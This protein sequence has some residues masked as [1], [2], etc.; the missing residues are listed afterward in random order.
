[1]LLA[2]I[3]GFDFTAIGKRGIAKKEKKAKGKEQERLATLLVR[4]TVR[5]ETARAE[6]PTAVVTVPAESGK[7]HESPLPRI[8]QEQSAT[9]APVVPAPDQAMTQQANEKLRLAQQ[10]ELQ[11]LAQRGT[12][13]QEGMVLIPAGEFL[14]GAEDGLRDARPMHRVFLSTF[15]LDRNE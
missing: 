13:M 10:E 9:P 3:E 7:R 14:M 12:A 4:T 5:I 2:N 11:R 6:A 8:A 1:H 15:W